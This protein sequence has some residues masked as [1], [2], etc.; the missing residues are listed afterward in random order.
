MSNNIIFARMKVADLVK[1][2]GEMLKRLHDSGINTNDYQYL[3]MYE[4]FEK[5][6]L[7]GH[8]TTWI[9]ADLGR[10]YGMCERKVYKVL[11]RFRKDCQISA[12]G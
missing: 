3:Q 8:K 12:A 2:S 11:S 1:F 6:R 5:L 9:V 4:E 10:R 7:E